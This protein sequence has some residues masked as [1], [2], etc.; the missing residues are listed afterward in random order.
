MVF[1]SNIFYF[2]ILLIII[3]L[4]P[5]H[6]AI[7]RGFNDIVKLILLEEYKIIEVNAKEI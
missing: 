3:N 7:D 1:I 2:R 6:M 4:T 5:L